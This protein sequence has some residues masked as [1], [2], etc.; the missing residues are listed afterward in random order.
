MENHMHSQ[1]LSLQQFPLKLK[2]ITAAHFY[3]IAVS[4]DMA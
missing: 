3:E 4:L 2:V 1:P